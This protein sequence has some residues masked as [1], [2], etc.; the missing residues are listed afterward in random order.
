MAALRSIRAAVALASPAFWRGLLAAREAR[1]FD[2]RYGTDTVRRVPVAAM[3]GV[4]EALAAHAVH[5]E[6]STIP[7]LRQALAAIA[8]ALGGRMP[9][10]AFLDVGSGKGLVVMQAARHPFRQIVGVEM[11]P[12]LHAIAGRNIARFAAAHP[13]AAPMH[14]VQGDALSCPLPA[15]PLV[16]Y[17]Y[18]PFDATLLAPFTARL[19]AIAAPDR[20]I[21]VAY[22]NPVHRDV[23]DRP[24]R[25]QPLFDNGRVVVYRCRPAR[26]TAA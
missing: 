7:K 1:A 13:D 5:Y 16:V 19:E 18:N 15:G 22:V 17:L 23:F 24:D 9:A 21:L 26:E 6:A 3:R 4:P 20:E 12:D 14:L 2:A 11:A 8:R 10:F 25:Y